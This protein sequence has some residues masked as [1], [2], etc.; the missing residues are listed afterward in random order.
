M[1]RKRSETQSV[2]S[3]EVSLGPTGAFIGFYLRRVHD[4]FSKNFWRARDRGLR[5]GMLTALELIRVNPGI[6]Q[7][8]LSLEVGL[9]K[10]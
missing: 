5:S 8:S 9:D 7:T 6:S 2:T 3:E 10:S 1:A 4:R